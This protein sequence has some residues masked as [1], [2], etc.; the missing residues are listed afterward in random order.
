MSPAATN[1][2]TRLWTNVVLI[3]VGLAFIGL[4]AWPGIPS[5]D[6]PAVAELGR[7]WAV[8]AGAGVLTIAALFAAQRWQT[9]HLAQL[10]IIAACCFLV[11]GLVS[12]SALGWE[13][14]V[15]LG[16]PAILLLGSLPFVGP[17][18]RERHLE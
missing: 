14:W 2:A 18:P 3:A 6:N 17:M 8:Y 1:P 10:C 13:L 9:R 15:T 16:V 12:Y 5:P 4:A 11:W 7:P